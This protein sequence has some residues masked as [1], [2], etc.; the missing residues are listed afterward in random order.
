MD[1]LVQARKRKVSVVYMGG[2]KTR[3]ENGG[4]PVKGYLED[5]GLLWRRIFVFWDPGSG[6]ASPQRTQVPASTSYG[7]QLGEGSPPER[8]MFSATLLKAK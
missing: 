5:R 8:C 2:K 1:Q 3:R 4:S 7:P 6:P